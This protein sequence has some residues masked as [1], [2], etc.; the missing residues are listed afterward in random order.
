MEPDTKLSLYAGQPIAANLTIR[1][2][3][4]WGGRNEL[5]RRCVL[6]FNVE[7]MVREWLISGPKRGD[8][9]ATVS[10]SPDV[11]KNLLNVRFFLNK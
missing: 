11:E 9:L 8:F 4:H 5:T 10:H 3:F 1:T 7:E 6:R 2:S